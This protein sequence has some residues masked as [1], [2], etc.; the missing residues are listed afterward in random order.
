M[1]D[2]RGFLRY[3]RENPVRRPVQERIQDWKEVYLDFGKDKLTVQAA[4]CMDCGIPF[5]HEGC[6]LA[7]LIPEWNDL[8]RRGDVS[9]AIRRLHA[10]NNFPDF[11]GR[12]CPAPCE[13]SCVLGIADD[14][15]SI[16]QIE[17]EISKE[18]SRR[19]LEPVVPS[20]KTNK[21]VA[22]VGSGPAGLACAQQLTRAGHSVTVF[23]RAEKIGGLL[24]YGIPEFKMEKSV[25]DQR[26]RQMEEEGTVFV[27]KTSVGDLSADLVGASA[28]DASVISAAALRDDYDA[29]ILCI[30]ATLPRDLPIEGRGAG[31]VLF[32]MD[33]L[34][35]ANLVC[36]GLLATPAVSAAGKDVVIIGGGDTGADCLGT[37]HR[38]GA[39]S[40]VQLEIMS[41]PPQE[42]RSDNPWPTWPRIFRISSA[43]EEGGSQMFSVA[44]KRFLTD[45]QNRLTG[46]EIEFLDKTPD[47][48]APLKDRGAKTAILDTQ[49]VLLAMGFVGP[50][51]NGLVSAL[52]LKLTERSNIAVDANFMTGVDG[53]FACGDASRGQSL[54]VWAIAEGRACAAKA[55]AYLMGETSL[56]APIIPGQ[57]ALA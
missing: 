24:R 29:V 45:D 36:E 54:V 18:A 42:R 47:N 26:I 20:R 19:G 1:A 11:T 31:G 49:L 34:K 55:D 8:M 53:I 44:T 13:G 6:P 39:K 35:Q 2:P 10:T 14:P 51:K 5:C 17:F 40:V 25:L 3:G 27:T 43:H 30:G 52:Q 4:R 37:A 48:F 9:E 23:E 56:P 22:V 32:A 41:K 16:K 7:N 21:K 28:P 15:V 46:L 12:V 50:E 33:Y 57:V 38:Q